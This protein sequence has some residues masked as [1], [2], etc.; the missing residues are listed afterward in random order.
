MLKQTVHSRM[1]V[2]GENDQ[3][4]TINKRIY[5]RVYDE[6]EDISKASLVSDELNT[7][8]TDLYNATKSLEKSLSMAE[9]LKVT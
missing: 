3:F 2:E 9:G 5:S 7:L 1:P 4:N 8:K 6:C